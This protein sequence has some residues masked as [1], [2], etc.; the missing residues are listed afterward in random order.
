PSTPRSQRTEKPPPRRRRRGGPSLTQKTVLAPPPSMIPEPSI[1][2]GSVSSFDR[3]SASDA[4]SRQGRRGS[5][6]SVSAFAMVWISPFVWLEDR[7]LDLLGAKVRVRSCSRYSGIAR[8]RVRS[9]RR[10][11]RGRRHGWVR[12]RC[13][14]PYRFPADPPYCSPSSRPRLRS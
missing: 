9:S 6:P 1:A 11:R 3:G 10:R 14:L 2:L 5:V 12:G 4:G 13:R 7:I 8:T